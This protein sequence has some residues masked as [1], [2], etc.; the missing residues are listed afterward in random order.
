[1]SEEDEYYRRNFACYV[2]DWVGFVT[3][4]AFVSYT[5]V[6]PSFVDQLTDFAPLIGLASTIPN[7]IWLLPQI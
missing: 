1:V 3:G 2:A 4:M 6:I 5:S 7:G